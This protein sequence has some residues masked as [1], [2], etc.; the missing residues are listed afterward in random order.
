MNAAR[1]ASLLETFIMGI[2]PITGETL[3]AEHVC[4]Q[5]ETLRALHLAVAALRNEKPRL[6]AGRPWTPQE[7]ETLRQLYR[8]G[9]SLD[10]IC[11]R[12]SRRP[13]GTENRLRHL[14]L[15]PQEN[16]AKPWRMGKIWSETE[17]KTLLSMYRA[18]RSEAE[19]A[20]A[21][22]RGARGGE[23]KLE[24][25]L[26]MQDFSAQVQ[27]IRECFLSRMPI[28]EIARETG[29]SRREV[30]A[31]LDYL[32]LARAREENGEKGAEGEG[33]GIQISE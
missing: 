8:G 12:L 24:R 19:I 31:R 10:A 5:P 30:E 6:N 32:G 22:G 28:S 20:S 25:L 33:A 9:V 26:E 18:G 11:A 7:D 21:L 29:L 2:D 3:D 14:G 27:K 15:L 23:I 17:E 16:A 13:R 1:A 4:A